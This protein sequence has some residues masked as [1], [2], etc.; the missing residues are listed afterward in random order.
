MIT[1]HTYSL[2]P[3]YRW[4]IAALPH[5]SS[6]QAGWDQ[7]LLLVMQDISPLQGFYPNHTAENINPNVVKLTICKNN[8]T[9]SIEHNR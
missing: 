9:I 7:W 3:Q 1:Q 2:L 5:Q 6:W 4:L 8:E